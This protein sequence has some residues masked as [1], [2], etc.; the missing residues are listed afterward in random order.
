MVGVPE[1]FDA[2]Q[3]IAEIILPRHQSDLFRL[4]GVEELFKDL[5]FVRRHAGAYQEWARQRQPAAVRASYSAYRELGNSLWVRTQRTEGAAQY[6]DHASN[7]YLP[8]EARSPVDLESI[9]PDSAVPRGRFLHSQ[10]FRRKASPGEPSWTEFFVS[11]GASNR[12]RVL[13]VTEHQ[14]PDQY[15]SHTRF[16]NDPRSQEGGWPQRVRWVRGLTDDWRSEDLTKTFAVLPTLP[17]EDAERIVS[18]IIDALEAGWAR[19][20]PVSERYVN[21]LHA[22]LEFDLRYAAIVSASGT[23]SRSSSPTMCCHSPRTASTP[24]RTSC[25]CVRSIRPCF[26]TRSAA[27]TLTSLIIIG[28]L[29]SFFACPF[30]AHQRH[31]TRLVWAENRMAAMR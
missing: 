24:R 19:G 4:L 13:K 22:K 12:I 7:L 31:L 5:D 1:S 20:E 18:L 8:T 21:K 16:R 11:L 17:R 2:V 14:E 15:W 3:V 27:S 25:A 23:A 10:Y 9:L 29:W 28:L 26:S 6:Y 30:Q